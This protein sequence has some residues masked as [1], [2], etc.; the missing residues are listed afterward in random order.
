MVIRTK[1]QWQNLFKQH[2]ESGVTAAQFCR[3]N[4]LCPKYFAKRKKDLEWSTSKTARPRLVKLKK[5]KQNSSQQALTLQC[6][7]VKLT[8]SD[9][10]SPQWLAQVI[11]ALAG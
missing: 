4:D 7:E 2:H 11:K 1:E 9:T 6:G 5:P 10:V 8:I 3:E